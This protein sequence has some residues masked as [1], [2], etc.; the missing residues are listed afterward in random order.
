MYSKGCFSLLFSRH[1]WTLEL[2]SV[3]Y[4]PPWP[5]LSRHTNKTQWQSLSDMVSTCRIYV[6][7]SL[8][9]SE[10][11][12]EPLF[13]SRVCL[14]QKIKNVL[15]AGIFTILLGESVQRILWNP[16][17]YFHVC[18]VGHNSNPTVAKQT[19]VTC[20]GWCLEVALTASGH[21]G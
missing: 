14:L 10:E 7:C 2:I 1:R 6:F 13:F 16:M 18:Q 12:Q 17:K 9:K 5:P 3:L 11:F 15:K 19:V 4:S 20:Q 21:L 8:S